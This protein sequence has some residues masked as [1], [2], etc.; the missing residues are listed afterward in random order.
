MSDKTTE[1]TLTEDQTQEL[2]DS[3][4]GDHTQA[5]HSNVRIV[6]GHVVVTQ[7]PHVP[8]GDG[9]DDPHDVLLGTVPEVIDRYV[10]H[11]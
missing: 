8:L 11:D 10:L 4:D 7:H 6:D 5:H 2:I 3:L 9:T 1:M